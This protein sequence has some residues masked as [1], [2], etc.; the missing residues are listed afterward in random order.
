MKTFM[1]QGRWLV[2]AAAILMMPASASAATN[3]TWG[4]THSTPAWSEAG[5]W[6]GGVA[7]SG[8]VGTLTFPE[9][10]SKKI[11]L[12][13]P[14]PE[15]GSPTCYIT[16]NDIE[17]LSAN[18][19]LIQEGGY[20]LEKTFTRVYIYHFSGKPLTLGEGGLTAIP[21]EKSGAWTASIMEMPILLGAPQTWSIS[22]NN[23]EG[24]LF[25]DANVT[26][27]SEPLELDL[28]NGNLDLGADVNAG[29]ISITGSGSV[30]MGEPRGPHY[31]GTLNGGDGSPVSIGE[32]ISVYDENTNAFVEN[33]DSIG[34]LSLARH[35][36]L[37]LGQPTFAGGVSM[38]VNGG[39]SLSSGSKLSL[40]YN[41]HIHAKGPVD[42]SGAELFIQDGFSLVDGTPT[43]NVLDQDTLISTTGE[44]RGTFA[45]IP[46]G[47]VMPLNCE[48]LTV[49]PEVRFTYTPHSVV[50]T[51]VERTTTDLTVSSSAPL[52]GQSV[53]YTA[54]VSPERHG[55]G[56]PPGAVE[57]LDNGQPIPSCSGQALSTGDEVSTATCTLSYAD[58]GGHSISTAYLGSGDFVGS[59][60]ASQVVTVKK[61]AAVRRR[62]SAARC[63]KMHGNARRR[64]FKK[65]RQHNAAHKHAA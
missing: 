22:G 50:A 16:K 53:T 61:A 15:P 42:L 13:P 39:V 64:C 8:S 10:T 38:G 35:A 5:N 52:V 65:A 51:L 44:L 17:G 41:S 62:T 21:N 25:L 45:G 31:A 47:A 11:C 27:P 40:L 57:F 43:C 28:N 54:A 55:E 4:G 34:G 59:S 49:P 26:G 46:D 7:P 63:R 56:S 30:F 12:P 14:P 60:S 37:Q 2:A 33:T 32:G 20:E 9:L 18:A 29:P 19:L 48:G 23:Y 58:A 1:R 3:Y 6:N 36:T 24:I